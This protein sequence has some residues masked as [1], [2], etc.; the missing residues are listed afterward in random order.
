MS[1]RRATRTDGSVTHVCCSDLFAGSVRHLAF[2]CPAEDME[3][4]WLLHQQKLELRL[5]TC[6]HKEICE[7]L[8]L[9]AFKLLFTR[10]L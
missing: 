6:D 1:M 10:G 7:Y 8:P 4:I 9:Y 5:E 3:G 2:G